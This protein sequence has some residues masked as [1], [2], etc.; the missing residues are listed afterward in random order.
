[1]QTES[2]L[3]AHV[4][5]VLEAAD[6]V[7]SYCEQPVWIRYPWFG[8]TRRY[9]PDLAVQ[10]GDGRVIVIEVKPRPLW[11]DGIN[12]AKWNAAMRWC[13]QRG[14]GFAVVDGRGHPGDLLG[15]SDSSDFAL[16]E[17]LTEHGPADFARLRTAWF[18][19]GR[20]WTP[21]LSAALRYGFAFRRAPFRVQRARR[22]PWL[23]ALQAH[24]GHWDELPSNS[25]S[26]DAAL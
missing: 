12:L 23:T 9:V 22:S 4:I 17:E 18:G 7:E 5:G 21:L 20:S 13:S 2:G 3:E 19:S 25:R 14:W 16:L 11:A 26:S 24:A 1:M 10:L 6:D 15:L 8:E